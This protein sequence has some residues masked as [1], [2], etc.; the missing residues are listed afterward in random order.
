MAKASAIIG[1]RACMRWSQGGPDSGVAH[2]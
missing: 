2:S 1:I